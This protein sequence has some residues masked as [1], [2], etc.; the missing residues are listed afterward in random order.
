MI[1]RGYRVQPVKPIYI[2]LLRLGSRLHVVPAPVA[3]SGIAVRVYPSALHSPSTHVKTTSLSH[4]S[5]VGLWKKKVAVRTCVEN[6]ALVADQPHP[7]LSAPGHLAE[8]G[9]P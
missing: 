3:S 8:A 9:P 6:K 7:G 4:S 1:I 2:S 5:A